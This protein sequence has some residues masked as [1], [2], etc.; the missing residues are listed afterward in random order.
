MIKTLWKSKVVQIFLL[1]IIYYLFGKLA[2]LLALPPGY[3][4][5][6]W[7]P[8]GLGIAAL[9]LF[10]MGVLPGIYLGALLVNLDHAGSSASIW[11]PLTI[12]VGNT[13]GPLI[14]TLA[15]KKFIAFPKTFYLEK[16]IFLFLLCA[17]PLAGLISASW[18][19][20]VLYFA[21][22]VHSNNFALNWLYWFT[23]DATGGIIFSP[24][25]LIFSA[26]SRKYWLNS[27]T[28]V[29]VP[30][31]IFFIAIVIVL[32]YFNRSEKHKLNLEF[33]QKAEFSFN[34]FDKVIK[35][36]QSSLFTLRSFYESSQEVTHNEF[37]NFTKSLLGNN[38]KIQA[39]IWISIPSGTSDSYQVQFI[40]PEIENADLKV[41]DFNFNKLNRRLIQE[42]LAAK[43]IVTSGLLSLDDNGKKNPSVFLALAVA[44]PKG[45][46]VELVRFNKVL[47]QI[48]S[49]IA[50]SSY[51]IVVENASSSTS[52]ILADSWS[53][54]QNNH[55]NH[56]IAD[57]Q[58]SSKVNIGDHQ[59][60]FKVQQDSS[61]K[62]GTFFRAV[63][64]LFIA[65]IL[66]F[67]ICALLLT[68]ATRIIR[69][70]QLVNQKTLHL[71]ELNLQLEKAS[72][73][74]SEFLANMSHE[75]RTPL[76]VLLGMGELL[77]ESNLD[78]DQRQYIKVSQKAGQNLLNIINDI[79]DI[80][81]IEANLVTLE[82]TEL[83]LSAVVD[84]VVDMFKLKAQEKRLSLNVTVAPNLQNIYLGDP[85]RIK[86]ILSNL[87]SNAI[88]FTSQ[89]SIDIRVEHNND[90]QKPGNILFTVT[91][92]GTGI[93]KDKIPQ[94]FQP[95]TQADS[96]ITRKFGGTG[97][98]LSISKRLCEMMNGSINVESKQ[99]EGS[100]FSCTL[101]L[102]FVRAKELPS[103]EILKSKISTAPS[104]TALKI[105]IVDDSSDNRALL[106]AYLKDTPHLLLE[107]K[108]GAEAIQQYQAHHPDLIIMDMQMPVM[109]G[110]A[111][112]QEIRKMEKENNVVR[113]PIWALTA[114]ALTDDIQK[115]LQAGCNLHLIKPIRRNDF[116]SHINDLT[117]NKKK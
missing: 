93:P 2:L 4:S 95:F 76:N 46:L 10:G 70:D 103:Q 19:I 111:A 25:A 92:T 54:N 114:Y 40:E 116:L 18:G 58:W 91:D 1:T 78:D 53:I 50:D 94:L 106:K 28:K 39:M 96:S 115:S 69:T 15:I 42:A 24:L 49:L 44:Q 72:K 9:L 77:Q 3:A 57:L 63:I 102:G 109:D 36:F 65:L 99:N 73:T 37:K 71:R 45:V 26:Q 97:L 62:E 48:S 21:H 41:I 51:R 16:D 89:G 61:L 13:T 79:L 105:L 12:A 11:L 29:L 35:S 88:K 27:L 43:N 38:S 84:E 14:A 108:D 6:M 34:L 113:I 8:T 75:I 64:S 74:K 101:D 110:Y 17:G 100:T 90:D 112:T 98:G 86:Q 117:Q 20:E 104:A 107:A 52:E 66:T 82:K 87:V 30:L 67:L 5:P 33:Y 68:V 83:D 81:K 80:S 55:A 47:E 85:T 32:E 22:Q 56:F 23:G 60:V 7:P 31:V 59:W